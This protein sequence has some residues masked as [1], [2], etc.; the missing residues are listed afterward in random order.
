MPN[1]RKY[2]SKFNTEQL[3]F[4]DILEKASKSCPKAL[5]ILRQYQL[6]ADHTVNVSTIS[7]ARNTVGLLN[8]TATFLGLQ[9]LNKDNKSKYQGKKNLLADHIVLKIESYLPQKCRVCKDD[10]KVDMDGDKPILNCALCMQGC[11]KPCFQA[12]LEI[13]SSTLRS[14]VFPGLVWLCH[15]C[16][17]SNN[18]T[19]SGLSSL[20]NDLFTHCTPLSSGVTLTTDIITTPAQDTQTIADSIIAVDSRNQSTSR[21]SAVLTV[22]LED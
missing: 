11:H 12:S 20:S 22:Q 14:V 10:Y 18:I 7:Q 9:I 13:D 17:T 1:K 6:N 2:K 16:E 21:D 4:G 19:S 15:G 5:P 3:A 8:T